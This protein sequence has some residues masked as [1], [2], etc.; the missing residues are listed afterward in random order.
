MF[1][2]DLKELGTKIINYEQKETIP[3]TDNENKYYEKQEKCHICQKE[4][5]YDKN[6]KMKFILYK[7]VR[8]HCH[9]TG[10]FR[11]AT[12]SIC[13][14][15]YKVPHEIPAKIHNGSKNDYHFIIKELIVECKGEFECLRENMEKY[16]DF[17]VPIK[18]ENDNDK[19]ITYKLKF[20]DNLSDIRQSEREF[21][22]FK[23]DRLNYRCKECKG[24]STKPVNELIEK[25][26]KMYQFCNG[27]LNKFVLLLRKGVYP[28]E[29]IDSWEKFHETSLPPKKDFYSELTLE[30]I[31]DKDHNH[32]QKVFE[33]YCTDMV[34]YHDFYVQTD[35]FWLEKFEKLKKTCI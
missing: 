14:L 7:K 23:K 10:K 9:Y 27:D 34:D 13:N 6:E 29:Y 22:G 1:C 5:C 28:Y 4:F 32:A 25:F 26:P 30:D 20:V 24:T 15:N 35:T 31:S 11:G 18:K 8:D 19:T 17:S 16:V 21:I 3:L 12:H 2:S 33:V